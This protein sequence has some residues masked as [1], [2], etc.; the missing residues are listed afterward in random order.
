MSDERVKGE[1]L[2]PAVQVLVDQVLALQQEIEFTE[3]LPISRYIDFAALVASATDT[4]RRISVNLVTVNDAEDDEDVFVLADEDE[5]ED[6]DV[7]DDD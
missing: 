3:S 2:E 1:V 6:E 5:F 4:V 7:E